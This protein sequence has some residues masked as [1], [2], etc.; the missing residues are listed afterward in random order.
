MTKT[1]AKFNQNGTH[2]LSS[3]E[4]AALVDGLLDMENEPGS[5]QEKVKRYKFGSDNLSIMG[6]YYGLRMI[7]ER[8]CRLARSVFLPFLRMHPRISAF[9]P[10]VKTYDH[11]CDELENFVSLTTSRIDALRS[12]QLIMLPP[13]FV[14]LLTNAYY[15]GNIA[16]LPNGRTEFTATENRVIKLVTEGLHR[17][18]EAAWRDVIHLT[19]SNPVHEDNLQFATFVENDE[20]VICCSFIIQLP[21]AD[22]ATI[23]LIYPLQALKPIAAHLRSRMQSDVV[24]DDIRWRARLQDAV[25]AVP[26]N[27]TARLAEP[28]VPIAA[29]TGL[30][31]GRIVPVDLAL[32]PQL[33]VEGM[34]L[35]EAEPGEQAGKAAISLTRRIAP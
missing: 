11:Y 6:D 4:V 12:H 20:K 21:D 8:F 14:S 2:K 13:N 17:A 24:D 35:F 18:L 26:L 25:L 30:A 32:R 34:P 1:M 7:N 29:L 5:T 23:D 9:P 22:P 33:L 15:G 28:R 3:N 16:Y 31:P 19:F 10:E 27:V